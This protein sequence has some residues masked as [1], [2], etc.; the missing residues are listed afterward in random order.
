M[1]A[2]AAVPGA[3]GRTGGGSGDVL[4]VFAA[5]SLTEALTELAPVFE[6]T[7]PGTEVRLTF[8]GSSALALQ[9]EQGAPADVFVAAD[10]PTMAAL[11][12]SGTA[13]QPHVVARNRLAI[14]V[15][16]GNP[17]RIGRLADLARSGLGVVLCAPGVPCGRLAAAALDKA[18]VVVRPVS[19]EANV[20]AV[21]ARI[22]LGQADAGLVYATDVRAAGPRAE[23]VPLDASLVGDRSLE[24]AYPMAV[25]VGHGG[26]TGGERRAVARAFVAF[27][28]SAPGQ[29]F[30][31]AAGF[32]PP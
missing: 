19:L 11:V 24:A 27:T 20:K 16:A 31:A 30:L 1:A 26:G 7:Q 8:G 18:G 9:I 23:G 32:L 25:I 13:G 5:S 3:C 4:E 6:A 28:R 10:E 15:A 12:E 22:T 29:R 21:V 17:Q 14:V 2:A